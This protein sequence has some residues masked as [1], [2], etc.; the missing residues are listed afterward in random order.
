[1]RN[2]FE[3]V[4]H[5]IFYLSHNRM[6][7]SGKFVNKSSI[8]SLPIEAIILVNNKPISEIKLTTLPFGVGVNARKDI[9]SIEASEQIDLKFI[10]WEKDQ[11]ILKEIK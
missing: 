6:A 8:Y 2:N 4:V 11:V 7:F 3:M 5:D 9:D 10:N 1:M